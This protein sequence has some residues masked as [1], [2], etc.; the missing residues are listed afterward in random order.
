[1]EGPIGDTRAVYHWSRTTLLG[2]MKRDT[3]LDVDGERIVAFG[4]SAGG[5]LAMVLVCISSLSPI[6]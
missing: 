5:T 3:G 1:M 6:L 4:G 2:L